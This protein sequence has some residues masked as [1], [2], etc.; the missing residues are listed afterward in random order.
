M[1]RRRESAEHALPARRRRGGR[2]NQ[3][4]DA[5]A[6]D[7]GT[8]VQQIQPG[9]GSVRAPESGRL[10]RPLI[11]GGCQWHCYRCTARIAGFASTSHSDSTS[12]SDEPPRIPGKASPRRLRNP[13]AA[14]PP[15]DER[16]AGAFRRRRTRGTRVDGQGAGSRRRAR[17]GRRREE[18]GFARRGRGSGRCDARHPA[19]DQTDHG[20]GSADLDRP[21]RVDVRNRSRVLSEHARRSGSAPDRDHGLRRRRHGHRRGRGDRTRK[22]RHR[23]HRSGR[24][25]AVVSG[26]ANRIRTR[27]R[28]RSAQAARRHPRRP[29]PALPGEGPRTAGAEPAREDHRRHAARPRREDRRGRQRVVQTSR[30]ARAR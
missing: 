23:V 9:A 29:V 16:R 12:P 22:D 19:R 4:C 17:K 21:D 27:A 10:E 6:S 15:R 20:R 7:A 14:G 26:A 18:G 3:I 8:T 24:R 2:W 1:S 25:V 13:G 5:R 28:L 11:A 30:P